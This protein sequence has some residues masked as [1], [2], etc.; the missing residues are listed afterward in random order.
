M[1]AWQ[2]S[3]RLLIQGAQPPLMNSMSGGRGCG[4]RQSFRA[5]KRL[6]AGHAQLVQAVRKEADASAA[7]S[8]IV[9]QLRAIPAGP[10]AMF[11]VLCHVSQL[12]A[13]HAVPVAAS[14]A[15]TQDQA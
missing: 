13:A 12:P 9:A 3:A 10:R 1:A 6:A 14:Q 5:D 8:P 7:A 15:G 11:R 2:G 4:G